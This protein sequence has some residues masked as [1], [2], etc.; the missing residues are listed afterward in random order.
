[1]KPLDA[2]DCAII[3]GLQG[4]FPITERPFADAARELGLAEDDLLARIRRLRDTGVLSR[5]GPLYHAERMGGALVLAAIAVP[6]SDFDRIADIVNAF[7]E[8]AHNY[9]RDH[10]LNM[11]FVVA[12]ETADAA[13]DVF[14]RIEAATGLAVLPMPKEQEFF[15]GLRFEA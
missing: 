8:I 1:M 10:H 2:T 13:A 15:V 7:P 3:N 6:E 11:W 9:E 4:G 12:T 14:R 5:F